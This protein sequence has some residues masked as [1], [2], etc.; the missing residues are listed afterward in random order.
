MWRLIAVMVVFLFIGIALVSTQQEGSFVET[1]RDIPYTIGI[2][3][4]ERQILD[5]YIPADVEDYPVLMFVSGGGW[6]DGNKDWV[7]NVG[8]T[9]ARSGI[10]VVTVNHRLAPQANFQQQVS[11]LAEA[12]AW[13][14]TRI[15][16][17]GGDPAR[18]AIGGHSAGGHLIGLLATDPAYLQAVGYSTE[19]VAGV[20]LVSAVLEIEQGMF[21]GISAMLPD[22]EAARAA[23]PLILVNAL[24]DTSAEQPPT[25]PPFLLLVAESDYD[26]LKTQAAAMQ[27]AL[28]NANISVQSATITNRD[29]FNIITMIGA[30]DRDTTRT[31]LDW[32]RAVFAISA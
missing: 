7:G 19:D 8:R 22:A 1:Q 2:S 21:S 20:L 28:E 14:K 17:Y 29:H 11:D 26:A 31:M 23:S 32:L 9:L 18:V 4:D 13:I 6:V 16:E 27:T 15:A 25:R 12:F 10:G 3:R 24:Q 30:G 5:V